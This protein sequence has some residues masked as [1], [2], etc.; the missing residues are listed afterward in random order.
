MTFPSTMVDRIVPATT[1][2]DI[3]EARRGCSALHDAAPVVAE[4]FSQWV[5]ED[6]FAARASARGRT[7]AR[8]SSPTS[9]R[10]RR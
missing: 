2:A 6:R 8:S 7:P 3:A 5:I 4:P 10:S 1:D 9:R